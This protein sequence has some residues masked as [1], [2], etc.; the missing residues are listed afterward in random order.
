MWALEKTLVAALTA[1]PMVDEGYQVAIMAPT[2]ILAEQHL[3]NFTQ[4]FEPLFKEQ[5]E[6]KKIAWL[7][8]KV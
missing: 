5:N 6:G 1:A 3:L 2:E 8:G 7:T 4:W